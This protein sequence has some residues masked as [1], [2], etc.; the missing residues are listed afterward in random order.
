MPITEDTKGLVGPNT[1]WRDLQYTKVRLLAQLFGLK[2]W[3]CSI[4]EAHSVC[5]G[6][7]ANALL[8]PNGRVAVSFGRRLMNA[9]TETIWPQK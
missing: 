1:T 9:V 4:P 7:P 6:A 5:Q 2:P 8:T 3:Y